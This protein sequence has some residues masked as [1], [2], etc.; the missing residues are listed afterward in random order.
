[1]KKSWRSLLASSFVLLVGMACPNTALAQSYYYAY[2][3]NPWTTPV[4]V[5]GGYVDA[6]NGNLH[7]EI[8]IASM[9]ERGSVPFRAA[10]VYDSHIWQ[11]V[12]TG[13]STSWK[14]TNIPTYGWRLVTSGLPGTINYTT[15]F[16]GICVTNG[17]SVEWYK[18]TNFTWQ[19]P[20][21]RLI[22]FNISTNDETCGNSTPSGDAL[23]NDGSGYHMYVI[24]GNS[25]T[26]YAP[27][28]TK[29]AP[30]VEDANGNFYTTPDSH[31]DVG[32]PLGRYPVSTTV[33]GSTT[34]YAVLNS[35]GG[36]SS[37]VVTWESVPVSTSFGQPGVTECNSS[38]AIAAIE[39]IALP[40]GTS[41]Q[42]TYDQGSTGTHYGTLTAVILPTGGT[43][44]YIYENFKD[45][46][47]NQNMYLERAESEAVHRGTYGTWTFAPSVISN[48]CPTTCSQSTSVTAP[49]GAVQSFTFDAILGNMWPY[50]ETAGDQTVNISYTSSSGGSVF[51]TGYKTTVTVPSGS[52]TKNTTLTYDTS[53]HGTVQTIKEWNFQSTG[54]TADRTTTY[55]YLAD[56]NENIINKKLS[57]KLTNSAGTALG[58]TDITYDGGSLTSK[59]G[60]INHDDVSFPA[61]YTARGNPTLITTVPAITKTLTYDST[62]QLL[63]S[64]D[65]NNNLT[66]FSYADA[67]YNDSSTGATSATPAGVT[68]AFPTAIVL[69]TNWGIA[70]TYFL[71]TSQVYTQSDQNG[72]T[73]TNHY[74]DTLSRPTSTQ[75]PIN[76]TS[77]SWKMMS[78]AAD[79]EVETD[80]YTGIDD[81]SPSLSCSSCRHDQIP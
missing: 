42:F 58:E 47:N 38:C 64:Y 36:T 72:F 48:A 56:S 22:T 37:F 53:N 27:D 59:T 11:Q 20:S 40:D 2:G 73:T 52:L 39:S 75:V 29:V 30:V 14:P 34:T 33:N 19:P 7:I 35:Q 13:S 49:S 3:S 71:G 74:L 50:T 54:P 41:Y 61:T 17:H 9:A 57:I 67:Y 18:Y 44:T 1:M 76:A 25:V 16:G 68:N 80:L 51:A 77:Y 60:V 79:S 4:P 8:P 78:Y 10:L 81:A 32:D 28:G 5:P 15:T 45:A 24:T 62:G 69:P 66:K 55:T 46:W 31:G 65:N 26:V 12:T 23:A 21:G 43:Y 6:A 70:Y 63:D